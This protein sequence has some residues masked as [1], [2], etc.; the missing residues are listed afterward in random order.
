M[1][2]RSILVDSDSWGVVWPVPHNMIAGRANPRPREFWILVVL[3]QDPKGGSSRFKDVG[4]L[5][6][7]RQGDRRLEEPCR[8]R[9]DDVLATRSYEG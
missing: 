4:E 8:L 5:F 2:E 3:G 7:E 9:V 1:S 6:G